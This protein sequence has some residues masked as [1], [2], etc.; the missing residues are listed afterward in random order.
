MKDFRTDQAASTC[1]DKRRR[2]AL[3]LFLMVFCLFAGRQPALASEEAPG[4]PPPMP[5]RPST[6]QPEI[7]RPE[8]AL[9][10]AIVSLYLPF[11][12]HDTGELRVNPASRAELLAFYQQYYLV[13]T[14]TPPEWTGSHAA[15][16]PGTTGSAFKDVILKRIRYFR[17]MAGVPANTIF[18]DESNRLAQAAALMMSVN[19]QLSHSPPTSWRCYSADGATGAGS[20]NLYLGNYDG[21]AIAGYMKDFGSGNYAAG[22]RRWILYPQTREMGT[23]D[24]PPTS[25]YSPSNALRV[26][27]NHMWEPRPATREEF[28]AWPPPG[29]VPYL[30]VY[31]RWSFS[32]PGADFSSAAVTMVSN[33]SGVSVNRAPV[34]NGYGE[35]TLVWIPLGM[36][37]SQSWPRPAS[38]TAYTVNLSNVRIGGSR[39]AS[40]IPSL[41]LIRGRSDRLIY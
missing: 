1:V 11:T 6:S 38:D 18:S 29:Y 9:R 23:G 24:I 21:S 17:A 37:D 26:F 3:L 4:L 15:C 5:E 19:G 20:S 10:Q 30:V 31:P 27:D 7:P 22:H 33:G 34:V 8:L 12:R 36:S 2:L 28:V 39:V 14:S 35:N 25:S 32:Y 16:S 40:A 41:C 13:D